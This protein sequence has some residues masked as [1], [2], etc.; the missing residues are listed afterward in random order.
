[1]Q[2]FLI[3][4]SALYTSHDF[5]GLTHPVSVLGALTATA[6]SR[7]PNCI[8][9]GI[10][11]VDRRKQTP[12]SGRA[13]RSSFAASPL[14]ELSSRRRRK[15]KATFAEM[16]CDACITKCRSGRKEE[17]KY[18]HHLLPRRR[19]LCSQMQIAA[20]CSASLYRGYLFL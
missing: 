20:G 4:F 14:N 3:S 10:V 2:N 13:T 12:Y 6:A 8:Q 19:F 1:M 17:R 5:S 7:H 11:V 15:T 18:H 16:R 9:Y